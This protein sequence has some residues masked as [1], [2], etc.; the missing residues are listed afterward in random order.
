M[1]F[2]RIIYI[3]L[4]SIKLNALAF[5]YAQAQQCSARHLGTGDLVTVKEKRGWSAF[6]AHADYDAEGWP[7]ITYGSDFNGLPHT[8]KLFTFAHECAHLV[9][10]TRNEF[11][12][13]CWALRQR[14]WSARE[15]QFIARYHNGLGPLFPQHGG[16]GAAFWRLTVEHCPEFGEH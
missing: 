2:K 7:T 16:S 13:N 3:S 4:L 10:R 1:M 9:L 11:E 8:M 12:A 6:W 14:N 5:T 15:L